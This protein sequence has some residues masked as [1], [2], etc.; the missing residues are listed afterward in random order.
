MNQYECFDVR[1]KTELYP[2]PL[3]LLIYVFRFALLYH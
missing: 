1:S 3:F 2:V